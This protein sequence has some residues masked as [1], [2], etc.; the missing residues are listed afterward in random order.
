MP[1]A[2]YEHVVI[3]EVWHWV[4]AA[5]KRALR[6]TSRCAL[7]SVNDQ[8]RTVTVPRSARDT[9][10]IDAAFR[11]WQNVTNL[12]LHRDSLE[13]FVGACNPGILRLRVLR[14]VG[15]VCTKTAGSPRHG[16]ACR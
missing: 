12:T 2:T 15:H 8:V 1:A 7:Q 11:R 16:R 9:D 14:L 10:T 13:S 5:T 4:D 3:P 6:L